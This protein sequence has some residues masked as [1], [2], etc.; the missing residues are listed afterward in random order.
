MTNQ[1]QNICHDCWTKIDKE[2]WGKCPKCNPVQSPE[3]CYEKEVLAKTGGSNPPRDTQSPVITKTSKASLRTQAGT[4][5]FQSPTGDFLGGYHTTENTTLSDKIVINYD[6]DVDSIAVYV[7]DIKQTNKKILENQ[8]VKITFENE[9]YR[10][11]F[12]DGVKHMK[13]KVKSEMGK[14]LTK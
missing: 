10:K 1:N 4:R 13:D 3:T 12:L 9:D 7:E 6:G 11:G 14:E 5:D 8:F 2:L